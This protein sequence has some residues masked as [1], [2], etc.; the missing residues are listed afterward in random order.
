MISHP[1]GELR[2]SEDD[3]EEEKGCKAA[4]GVD[5]PLR[6]VMPQVYGDDHE[7]QIND[8]NKAQDHGGCSRL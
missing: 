6:E 3:A 8:K 4:L 1:I 7:E 2:K 5:E